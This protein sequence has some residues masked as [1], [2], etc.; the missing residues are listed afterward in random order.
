MKKMLLLAGICLALVSCKND[1]NDIPDNGIKSEC[2]VSCLLTT[3]GENPQSF[4][5]Y[6][7]P[8]VFKYEFVNN[9]MTLSTDMLSLS[10]NNK[11][12]FESEAVKFTGASY[13]E[14]KALKF[15]V[16][17][18]NTKMNG[19]YDSSYNI[20][21]LECLLT[22]IYFC[23]DSWRNNNPRPLGDMV[24]ME[25]EIGDKYILRTFPLIAGYRGTSATSFAM[26][27]QEQSY[28]SD[29][30]L[31]AVAI[32]SNKNT[33]EVGLYNAKF[34]EQMPQ[35]TMYLRGLSV[36]Y[37]AEGYKIS[38]P[39]EGVIPLVGNDLIPYPDYIFNNFELECEGEKLT[40]INVN[41]KVAGKFNGRF[42]GS[43]SSVM[44]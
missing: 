22:D 4:P 41:F 8:F 5:V 11:L 29:V 19:V 10:L 16:P 26:G 9:T 42:N 28:M 25:C 14:G 17:S 24:I 12:S 40:E 30:T 44:Y 38:A 7:V 31:Y 20:T 13:A 35:L 32:D 6:N 21:N 36:E 15:E 23:P 37:T 39:E 3:K 2:K 33:A 43:L 1:E 27:G 18:I 34:A